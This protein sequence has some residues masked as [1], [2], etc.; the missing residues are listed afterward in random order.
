[1][2]T[3]GS[4]AGVAA[5]VRHMT[6]EDGDFDT[7]TAP[8]LADVEMWLNQRAAMLDG[9]LANCGYVTPVTLPS[10]KLI[11]D[12]YANMGAAGDCELSQRNAGYTD[13]DNNYREIKFLSEFNKAKDYICSGALDELG[14]PLRDDRNKSFAIGV[15]KRGSDYRVR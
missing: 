7:T 6:N 8:P 10:A 5:W 12:R 14:V 4:V 9:W 13:D 11:L 2:S 1:M 3:Y 15:I